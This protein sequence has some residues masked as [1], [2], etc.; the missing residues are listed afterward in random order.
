[1]AA[2][3][4]AAVVPIL[5]DLNW[6]WV[7]MGLGLR[8]RQCRLPFGAVRRARAVADG[9]TRRFDDAADTAST[10]T[11]TYMATLRHAA[12]VSILFY[13]EWFCVFEVLVFCDWRCLPRTC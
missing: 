11:A 1:M 8:W 2:L 4:H 3:S 6:I 7:F 9:R 12:V 13:L 5:L 10:L